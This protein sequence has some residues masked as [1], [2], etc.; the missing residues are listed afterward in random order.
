M[1]AAPNRKSCPPSRSSC[2]DLVTYEPECAAG[3]AAAAGPSAVTQARTAVPMKERIMV[4]LP[5]GLDR[6]RGQPVYEE[7]LE[8][9]EADHHREADDERGRHHLIPVHLRLV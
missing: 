5:S 8:R 9:Q 7:S 4:L 1:L 6:A 2:P 3:V